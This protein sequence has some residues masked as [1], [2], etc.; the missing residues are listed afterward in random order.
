MN[1]HS[2]WAWIGFNAYV[3]VMLAVDLGVFNRSNHVICVREALIWSAVWIAQALTFNAGVYYVMGAEKALQFL[4]GYVIEKSLSVDN[5]FVFLV[6]FTYFK[7][8]SLYQRKVLL[9]GVL[10]ALVMRATLIGLGAA[11]LRRFH[12]VMYVFGGFLVITGIRMLF[13]SGPDLEPEKNPVVRLVRKLVPCTSSYHDGSFFVRI[14]GKL[15]ATPLLVVIAVVEVTDLVFAVDSIPAIFSI[16]TDPFIVYTSNVFAIM[17]LRALYFAL[18]GV[19]E[20]FRFLNVGLAVVLSFVGVKMLIVDFWKIPTTLA[21]GVV[22]G[23]LGLAMIFSWLFPDRDKVKALAA[24]ASAEQEQP[25]PA[26]DNETDDE[27]G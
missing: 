7:V 20:M 2:I 6:I 26:P 10:G 16:T 22:G 8:N 21:L 9:W 12:W 27:R 3:L 13:E 23:V 1:S 15:F 5:L 24:Q 17:G 14:D 4:T 25:A 18:A 19:I 11:L